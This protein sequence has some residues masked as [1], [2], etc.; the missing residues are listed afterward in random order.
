LARRPEGKKLA[1]DVRFL[2]SILAVRPDALQRVRSRLRPEEDLDGDDR[3]TYLRMVE[4]LERGGLEALV[5]ELAGYPAE[6]QDLVRRAW[7]SPPPDVDDSVVDDVVQNLR[8][9]SIKRR[10]RALRSE[11]A[12]AERRGDGELVA[13]LE[14]ELRKLVRA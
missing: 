11:L 13:T 10:H 5:R 1:D 4:T 7:A 8:R 3:A 14:A 9:R 6:E 2:L 12:E